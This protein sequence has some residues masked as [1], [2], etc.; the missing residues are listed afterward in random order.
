MTQSSGTRSSS[1]GSLRRGQGLSVMKQ[2]SGCFGLVAATPVEDAGAEVL[3]TVV[4]VD[5]QEVLAAFAAERQREQRLPRLSFGCAAL[6]LRGEV[7]GF[8]SAR[9]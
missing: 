5:D 1:A 8:G 6:V 9:G 3:A 7:A 4:E 2:Q